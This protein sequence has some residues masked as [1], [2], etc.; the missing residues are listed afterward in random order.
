VGADGLIRVFGCTRYDLFD[1]A[2]NHWQP[3][4]QLDVARCDPVVVAGSDGQ[5]YVMGG[6]YTGSPGRLLESVDSGGG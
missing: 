5:V 1:A 2:T 3:G 4:R 6:I